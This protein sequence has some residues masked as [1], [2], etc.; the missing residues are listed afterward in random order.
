MNVQ[1]QSLRRLDQSALLPSAASQQCR[2]QT[3]NSIKKLLKSGMRRPIHGRSKRLFLSV[4][5]DFPDF[6]LPP[7]IS[8]E[9][10]LTRIGSG[11]KQK[12]NYF[13]FDLW[14]GLF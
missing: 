11:G 3:V 8:E 1:E 9:R 4:R 14:C 7:R 12:L 6:D 10:E 13:A 2:R 5:L